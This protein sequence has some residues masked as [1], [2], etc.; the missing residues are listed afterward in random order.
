MIKIK[1]NNRKGNK[2]NCCLDF[3]QKDLFGSRAKGKIQILTMYT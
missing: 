2:T 1:S 3:I